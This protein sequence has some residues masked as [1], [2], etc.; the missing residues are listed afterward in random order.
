[1]LVMEFARA[2]AVIQV[3]IAS[4]GG[5][6]CRSGV[7]NSWF[8]FF[9]GISLPHHV[10]VNPLGEDDRQKL[11]PFPCPGNIQTLLDGSVDGRV[12]SPIGTKHLY[13]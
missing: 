8:P 9:G 5:L 3:G 11:S 10:K 1:V 4:W 2:G 7:V 13:T 6:G 12:L